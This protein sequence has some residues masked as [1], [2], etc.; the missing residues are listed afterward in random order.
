[1]P[2]N[3]DQDSLSFGVSTNLLRVQDVLSIFF[4]NAPYKEMRKTSRT[5]SR[6]IIVLGSDSYRTSLLK[7]FIVLY[8]K[9]SLHN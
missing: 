7:R 1:M 3:Y 5:Y 2:S 9:K 4:Y 6:E 8:E